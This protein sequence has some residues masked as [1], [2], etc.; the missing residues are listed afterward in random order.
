MVDF[1][2][3]SPM[4]IDK[5]TAD[6][7]DWPLQ[8]T[9]G[10]L[11]FFRVQYGRTCSRYANVGVLGRCTRMLPDCSVCSEGYRTTL[12]F[13]CRQCSDG[14]SAVVFVVL[15]IVFLAALAFV[16]H[17]VSI[18]KEDSTRGVVV[19]VEKVVPLQSIKIIIVAWQIVTQVS[20]RAMIQ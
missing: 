18:E 17:M 1:T 12:A 4:G 15:A 7:P 11:L 3:D 9:Q 2:H 20:T 8:R 10:R 5:G 13:R 6:Q 19:R 16:W 14:N